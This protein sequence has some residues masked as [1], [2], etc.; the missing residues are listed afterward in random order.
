MNLPAAIEVTDG[1]S[2]V[3][4]SILEKANMVQQLGGIAELEKMIREL[5]DALQRN[6]DILDEVKR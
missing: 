3:P 4:P 6:R 5:P 2:A 1:S